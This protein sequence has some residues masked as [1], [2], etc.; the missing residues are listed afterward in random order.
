MASL[1]TLRVK[2]GLV[3]SIIIALAL[4]AFIL[5]LKNEMGFSGN[6]PKVGEIDGTKIHYSEYYNQYEA[7]KAQNN[8]QESDEQQSAALANAVWQSLISKYVM[9]PGFSQLGLRFSESE[10]MDM[11]SGRYPSQTLYQAFAD[12]STGNYNVAAVSEFLAQAE[13][14]PQARQM[15][16]QLVEQLRS[17]REAQKYFALLRGGAYVNALEVANGVEGANKSFS[18]KWAVKRYAS[19][20]DSLVTVSASDL[21]NYYNA[22]KNGFRQTP[23]RT[24]SYVLFEVAPTE[25]DLLAIEKKA[26]EVAAEFAEVEDIRAFVRADVHGALTDNYLSAAQLP[27]DE[28]EA[29]MAGKMYG[30]VLKNNEWSMARVVDVKTAPDSLGIRHIVLNYN[31]RALADSLLGV[32]RNGGDF[33]DLATRY[34]LYSATAANGGE[35]GVLPFASFTGEFA[36][37]L[38]GAKTGDIVEVST[39]DVLQLMQVYRAGKPEKHVMVASIVY[40][41]EASEATRRDIHNQAGSFS[42][43]AKESAKAFDNAAAE[44]ALTPRIASLVEGDRML[45]GLDDSR[46]VARWAFEAKRGDVSEIFTVG[47]DYVVA[48][49]GEINDEEYTPLKKIEAQVRAQVLRDKKYDY[50]VKELAGATLEEQAASLGAEVA[51]FNEVSMNAYYVDGIGYEPRVVGA[52]TAGA[53]GALLAPVKGQ[54]GLYLVRVDAVKEAATQTAEAEKARAQATMEN[55][56]ERLAVPAIEQMA[57]IR[58]LRGKYF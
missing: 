15:W 46:E 37:K 58:D 27:A 20:P 3:L 9:T 54:S 23:N 21:K 48:L 7:I 5:S 55:M 57:Q 28:A 18:G 45:R 32:L 4:L 2:F 1:N 19:V 14:D 56:V 49:L 53:E 38:A 41:L 36:E 10:R 50:I 31:D 16:A 11:I 40:P 42:V 13:T 24:V 34:S 35:V 33:A 17:E 43:K 47:K 52:I 25:D 51:D 12:P 6:D 30:P 39:G 44:A 8:V 26:G 22:H 29:L